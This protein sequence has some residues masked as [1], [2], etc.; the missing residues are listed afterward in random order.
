MADAFGQ[1]ATQAP[2]PTITTF[3]PMMVSQRAIN[4]LPAATC[5]AAG[6]AVLTIEFID[7]K[8]KAGKQESIGP[9][10]LAGAVR[11]H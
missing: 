3:L 10:A 1:A 2:H 4:R 7:L 9:L 8:P 6:H 5:R 11:P